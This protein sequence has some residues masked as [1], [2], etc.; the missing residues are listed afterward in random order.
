[1]QFYVE[2]AKFATNIEEQITKLVERGMVIEDIEKAK[3]NLLDIGYFRLGFYWFPFEKS[4]PR[5]QKRDLALF[6]IGLIAVLIHPILRKQC[7]NKR[8]QLGVFSESHRG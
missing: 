6:P 4:Y 2:L 5:K 3:E 1:M 8:F 7:V